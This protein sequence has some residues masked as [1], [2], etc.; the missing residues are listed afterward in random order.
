MPDVNQDPN[1]RSDR[2][3]ET[4]SPLQRAVTNTLML[5]SLA[6]FTPAQEQET[7]TQQPPEARATSTDLNQATL[8]RIQQQIP[9]GVERIETTREGRAWMELQKEIVRNTAAGEGTPRLVD[10]SKFM[11]QAMDRLLQRFTGS[12]GNGITFKAVN[13]DGYKFAFER[14]NGEKWYVTECP[15]YRDQFPNGI[16]FSDAAIEIWKKGSDK[17][18]QNEFH[19]SGVFDPWNRTID[20]RQIDGL[21]KE[22]ERDR[23][24]ELADTAQVR[25]FTLTDRP[26]GYIGLVDGNVDDPIMAGSLEDTKYYAQLLNSLTNE[27]GEKRFN[28]VSKNGSDAIAVER[29]PYQLLR[30][31]IKAMHDEGVRDFYLNFAGHGNEH[32]VYFASG[33]NHFR[34]SPQQVHSIFSEFKDSKF[35]VDTIACYGGGLAE[36]MKQYRDPTGE[37]GRVFMKLQAKPYSYNQEGRLEGVEGVRGQPKVHSSYYQIFNADLL[38]KGLGFGEA[39]YQADLAAKKLIPCDAEGWM[40]GSRGGERTARETPDSSNGR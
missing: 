5:F 9:E 32:G 38:M 34:L 19:L 2:S 22:A 31:N 14:E 23:A 3:S 21:M 10:G 27:R 17:L 33:R 18:T 1:A 39:H 37:Q 6:S 15:Y 30:R 25:G 20:F 4:R 12:S 40:S 29:D 11:T 16:Q 24:S 8:P 13:E 28:L 7:N 35:V 26:M 36:A